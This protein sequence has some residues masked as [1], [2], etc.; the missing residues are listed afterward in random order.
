MASASLQAGDTRVDVSI[1]D[2]EL[3]EVYSDRGQTVFVH[4]GPQLSLSNGT[5]LPVLWAAVVNVTADRL[6]L[7]GWAGPLA[8]LRTLTRLTEP[9]PAFHAEVVLASSRKTPALVSAEDWFA[10]PANATLWTQ[11]AKRTADEVTSHWDFKAPITL[12]RDSRALMGALVPDVSSLDTQ[13]LHSQPPFLDAAQQPARLGVGLSHTMLVTHSTYRRDTSRPLLWIDGSLRWSYDVVVYDAAHASMGWSAGAAVRFL[14]RRFGAASLR[15]SSGLQLNFDPHGL[16][17]NR[18]S[19]SPG[20]FDEWRSLAW[21]RFSPLFW[22]ESGAAGG[23]FSQSIDGADEGGFHSWWSNP[24]S[25]VGLWLFANETLQ[26]A[27]AARSEKVVRLALGAP[28]GP[29]TGFFPA[30]VVRTQGRLVWEWDEPHGPHCC[31]PNASFAHLHHSSWTGYWLLRWHALSALPPQGPPLLRRYAEQLLRLQRGDGMWPAYWDP[32]TG[33]A[34]APLRDYNAE[35]ATSALFLLELADACRAGR[36]PACSSEASAFVAAAL[37]ALNFTAREVYTS[38]RWYDFETFWS[39]SPKPEGWRDRFTGQAA[40]N[41]LAKLIAPMA[42]L[43][44]AEL[45]GDRQFWIEQGR[46]VLDYALLTQQVW[47]HPLLSAATL[48]GTTTQNTDAEWSDA[49]QAYLAPTL[50]AYYAATHELSYLERGVA[51]LRSSFAVAPYENYAHTGGGQGDPRVFLCCGDRPGELSS[52]H[53]GLMSAAASVELVRALGWRDAF[54]HVERGHAVG[55]NGCTVSLQH[56]DAA[57]RQLELRIQSVLRWTQPLELVVAGLPAA[58]ASPAS[59]C[60][61]SGEALWT[62]VINQCSPQGPFTVPQLARGVGV[63]MT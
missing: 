61:S 19:Q 58:A 1:A 54:V 4:S 60:G 27:L 28:Q 18:G 35:S 43:R 30:K 32:S 23:F 10:S 63:R 31:S 14:W 41:N 55:I 20:T 34:Q 39:C 21:E 24:R 44:A 59:P 9:A 40:E 12:L 26:P 38:T 25:A 6:V 52:P 2:A 48:G 42:F 22:R 53:W 51:A 11:K 17:A 15:N 5:V 16:P 8:L 56:V 57:R 62:L 7:S 33:V 29:T 50:F 45:S 37:R 49:R 36:E 46:A 3:T 47:S 13:R